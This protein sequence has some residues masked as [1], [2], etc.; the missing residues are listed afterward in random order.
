GTNIEYLVNRLILRTMMQAQYSPENDGHYGLA[1]TAYCHF[2]SPIR[3]YA[4]LLVHR[5]L[6]RLIAGEPDK[7]SADEVQ[8]IC[9]GL[10]AL[11]RKAM[12]AEREIQ[13]RSAILA[14]EDRIG[15]TMRGVI[16]GVADFGFWVELLDMPVDGLVR[17]ATLDDFYVF[18]PERQDLLG[19]R[20]GKTFA[21]GQTLD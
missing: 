21:M 14:L 4:D 11:E 10:N 7:L 15:E 20:T 2:T 9:E 17:L 3:R 8:G 12:E 16:S 5:S 1:S 13:K 18:D 19:Q 6:K